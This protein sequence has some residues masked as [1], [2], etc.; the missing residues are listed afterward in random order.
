MPNTPMMIGE[1]CTAYC[2]GKN[3]TMED[4][5]IVRRILEMSGVCEKVPE[6]HIN[7][8]TALSGGG[9]SFVSEFIV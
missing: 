9:P 2:L 5:L 6:N 7:A 3:I 4:Q 8:V 1:G